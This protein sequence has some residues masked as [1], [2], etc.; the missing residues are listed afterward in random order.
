MFS[1]KITRVVYAAIHRPAPRTCCNILSNQSLSP[2]FLAG[3]RPF[4]SK[5]Q[6]NQSPPF[7]NIEVATEG[8]VRIILINRP[9]K[10]NCV[11]K[12]TASELFRAF[13][14]YK[15]SNEAIKVAVLYGKGGNFC[16]GY[17][18]AEVA[19]ATCLE[20]ILIPFDSPGQAPMVCLFSHRFHDIHGFC[21]CMG[22][23]Q[24]NASEFRKY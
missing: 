5:T 24:I 12:E 13:L 17:D 8:P 21:T 18:L 7:K 9:D 4:S 22:P 19:A 20:E 2:A 23:L 6:D 3:K 15:K 14:D 11:N 10:R 16:A 1:L